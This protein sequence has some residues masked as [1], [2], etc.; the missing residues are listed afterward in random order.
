MDR[1]NDKYLWRRWRRYNWNPKHVHYYYPKLK[2]NLIIDNVSK[3]SD[4]TFYMNG[5]ICPCMNEEVWFDKHEFKKNH[6]KSC[7]HK[8][9]INNIPYDYVYYQLKN[10]KKNEVIIKN[11]K[12]E[13]EL[14]KLE[15]EKLNRQNERLKDQND[16]LKLK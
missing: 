8:N 14:I 12:F 3:I 11:L 7:I 15:N 4:K 6:I 9:W 1:S 10:N 16:K 13:N 5:V 2:N